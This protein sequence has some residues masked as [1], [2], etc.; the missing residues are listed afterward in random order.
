MKGI[1]V[2]SEI[3]ERDRKQQRPNISLERTPRE[4][5]KSKS[6]VLRGHSARGC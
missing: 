2:F 6:V 1:Y 5:P 3:R 4:A